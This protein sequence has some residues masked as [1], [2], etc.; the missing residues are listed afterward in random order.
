[1]ATFNSA[2]LERARAKSLQTEAFARIAVGFAV[3]TSYSMDGVKINALNKGL[4]E[5]GKALYNDPFARN[6]AEICVVSF[7]TDVKDIIDFGPLRAQVSVIPKDG[8]GLTV[9]GTTALGKGVARV[10]DKIEKRTNEYKTHVQYYQPWL[11]IMTDGTPVD[12]DDALRA[13][14]KKEIR[15]LVN[16]DHLIVIPIAIGKD[17]D[18]EELQSFSPKAP[19]VRINKIKDFATFFDWLGGSVAVT[20]SQAVSDDTTVSRVNEDLKGIVES[21]GV[22]L[23]GEL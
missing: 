1:M 17:A 12:D 13:K 22:N 15:Q 18:I 10:L 5:F 4:I 19:V 23:R 7:D 14:V 21:F 6:R 20:S 9:G 11:V 8:F 2:E 3:D 16:T